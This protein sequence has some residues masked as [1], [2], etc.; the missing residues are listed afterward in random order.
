MIANPTREQRLL[1]NLIKASSAG[2]QS[3][4]L[5]QWFE[6]LDNAG[7]LIELARVHARL[8]TG[9][10]LPHGVFA[11]QLQLRESR[12]YRI[13]LSTD[14]EVR[15]SLVNLARVLLKLEGEHIIS[16]MLRTPEF[17][18]SQRVLAYTQQ[19]GGLRRGRPLEESFYASEGPGVELEKLRIRSRFKIKDWAVRIGTSENTYRK[20]LDEGVIP[21]VWLETA[22]QTVEA[23]ERTILQQRAADAAVSDEELSFAF[24]RVWTAYVAT[25]DRLHS[26]AIIHAPETPAEKAAR[27]AREDEEILKFVPSEE[28]DLDIDIGQIDDAERVQPEDLDQRTGE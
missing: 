19:F 9:I 12:S 22:R 7:W 4:Q 18:R 1:M 2:K 3:R 13:T 28:E 24:G 16:L 10:A 8:C 11:L 21:P 17:A 15:A 26:Q 14:N 5:D 25:T 23:I 6:V 27:E 20:R